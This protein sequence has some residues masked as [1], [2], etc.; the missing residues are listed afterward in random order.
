MKAQMGDVVFIDY[1]TEFTHEHVVKGEAICIYRD[2]GQ[3]LVLLLS[4]LKQGIYA[5][6]WTIDAHI[7]KVLKNLPLDRMLLTMIKNE[8]NGSQLAT[9]VK[10]KAEF[11][12]K[13][14]DYEERLKADHEAIFGKE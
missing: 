11:D 6:I 5:P 10:E 3:P 13:Y 1:V 4:D 14:A 12:K 7:S 8:T 9:I 2:N